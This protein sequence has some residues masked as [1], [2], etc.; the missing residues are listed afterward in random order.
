MIPLFVL[1]LGVMAL[2]QAFYLRRDIAT[3]STW[4]VTPGRL[5]KRGIRPG[6]LGTPESGV[7]G[8]AIYQPDIEYIYTVDGNARRGTQMFSGRYQGYDPRTM[9]RKVNAL[10]AEPEVHYN[11]DNPSESY[12]VLT[13]LAWVWFC[14]LAGAVTVLAGAVMLLVRLWT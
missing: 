8:A 1:F 9:R 5:E 13:S 10:P 14:Y 7:G 6:R 4:K 12:L 3:K 2:R 11:P